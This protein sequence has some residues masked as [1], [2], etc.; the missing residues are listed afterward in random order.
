MGIVPM[1]IQGLLCLG[2]GMRNWPDPNDSP[3]PARIEAMTLMTIAY[4]GAAGGLIGAI[5]AVSYL[6]G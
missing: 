3:E 6:L 1:A 2:C 5:M 4:V